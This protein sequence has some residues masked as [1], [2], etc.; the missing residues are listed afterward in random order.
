MGDTEAT[1]QNRNLHLGGSESENDDDY[2]EPSFMSLLDTPDVEETKKELEGKET[3]PLYQ[4]I[5]SHP[6]SMKGP[7]LKHSIKMLGRRNKRVQKTEALVKLDSKTDDG[8]SYIPGSLRRK[9]PIEVPKYLKGN[10]T[11]E[12]IFQEA[13]D[14]NEED[15]EKKAELVRKMT[16][17]AKKE[18]TALCQTDIFKAMEE[19]APMLAQSWTNAV[20]G[21][22]ID[23][24]LEDEQLGWLAIKYFLCDDD[25]KP[26]L[27]LWGFDGLDGKQ[28]WAKYR[29]MFNV[30]RQTSYK[31][32]ITDDAYA[33]SRRAGD[34]LAEI[35]RAI[36]VDL[37]RWHTRK[38][39]ARK[40]RAQH[41][42]VSKK[43][44]AS[45]KQEEMARKIAERERETKEALAR[46]EFPKEFEERMINAAKAT[47]K[48][49][50]KEHKEEERK[51]SSGDAK[52]QTSRPEKNG[53]QRKEESTRSRGRSQTRSAK[54]W[55]KQSQR[56]KN[57]SA[58]RG[59]RSRPTKSSHASRN[60]STSNRSSRPSS[61][62]RRTPSRGGR[63]RGHGRGR[64]RGHESRGG[65][66]GRHSDRRGGRGERR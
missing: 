62:R 54:T 47:A 36:T 19:I 37:W 52:T 29:E 63:G 3:E 15:K 35:M 25:S 9:N 6:S 44:A 27:E 41:A 26:L 60:A 21:D 12:S 32:R 64:G 17:A 50:I 57:S 31:D 42:M 4:V 58:P 34:S 45:E 14:Q 39:R 7:V 22:Y 46:G 24:K 40:Q 49:A 23:I 38:E 20:E 11:M 61:T 30:P 43:I 8:K 2:E 5:A 55:K 13:H 51:K 53:A 28:V 66:G 18:L 33:I 10:E 1:S 56:Q 65:R 48:K 16:A 59:G